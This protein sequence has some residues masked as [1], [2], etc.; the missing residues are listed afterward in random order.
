[1]LVDDAR[2]AESIKR[3][4]YEKWAK[5]SLVSVV[6]VVSE[7]IHLG[8][9]SIVPDRLLTVLLMDLQVWC[10]SGLPDS[11]T[12]VINTA[13]QRRCLSGTGWGDIQVEGDC[14]YYYAF[15]GR[16]EVKAFDFVII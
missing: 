12:R 4:D 15:I 11:C 14:A 8:H 13:S 3:E 5:R 9:G 7:G 10:H 16:L 1:V 2:E 6:T